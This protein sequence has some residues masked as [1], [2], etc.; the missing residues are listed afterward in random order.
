[1][2]NVYIDQHPQSPGRWRVTAECYFG[3]EI[4]SLSL[5]NTGHESQS[6]S[7]VCKP[8]GTDSF[9]SLPSETWLVNAAANTPG[10]DAQLTN[11]AR[12]MVTIISSKPKPSHFCT[13]GLAWETWKNVKD[14]E[15]YRFDDKTVV[16]LQKSMT[17]FLQDLLKSET[18]DFRELLQADWR[19]TTERLENYYGSPWQRR[20]HKS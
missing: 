19:Y 14:Q 7:A 3:F 9:D 12:R 6:Q 2:T 4:T 8:L 5:P 15:L 20:R 16:D 17:Q 11:A 18:S 10:I 1:M 13:I